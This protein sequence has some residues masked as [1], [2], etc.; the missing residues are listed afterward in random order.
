MVQDNTNLELSILNRNPSIIQGPD[1]LHE[2]VQTSSAQPAID[3]L[4]NGSKRQTYSYTTLHSLSDK[5]A[6]TILKISKEAKDS[7]T[8]IP[9]FL[10]QCPELYI[11]LLAILKAGKAFCPLNLDTPVERLKFIL[12]DLSANLLISTSTYAEQLQIATDTQCVLI[13]TLLSERNDQPTS[14]LPLINN[15]D[16]AYVLYTSGSTGLPKAVSVSHRAITQS[17]LAHDRHIPEFSRFL[18]FAAPTFDVSIFEIFF[19]W[20]RGRTLV[21]CTRTQMLDELPRI[22]NDLEVDAAEL[23]PTVVSNLLHGR[24]SVLGLKLLLTIGEMLTQYVIDEYGGDE[25]QESMLW[26][27]YGPTEAAVH[28]TLQPRLSKSS[29]IG[30]IGFP[31]DT[32]SSLIVT[33]A[34]EGNAPATIEILPKGEVGELVIAGPQVAKEYLNRPELTTA[35]FTNHPHYGYLYRTGDL[36]RVC[37]DKNLEFMGRVIAGQVKLR[38]Q[39]VE[40]GEIEKIVLKVDG[41]RAAIATIIED[42]L[43]VFCATG[44]RSISRADVLRTCRL[45]LPKSMVPSDVYFVSSMPQLPSGKVDKKALESKYLQKSHCERLV[46][47]DREDSVAQNVLRVLKE[48]TKH[49]LAMD[50]DLASVGLDSLKAIRVA[51]MLRQDGYHLGAVDILVAAT[52]E[53]LITICKDCPITDETREPSEDLENISI[54]TSISQL[55]SFRADVA[56][57]FRCT[58]L[59]EAMLAETM[60][61]PSAYCNW[62]EVDLSMSCTYEQIRDGLLSLT[63]A[64]E[65]L[66]TGFCSTSEHAATFVQIVWKGLLASQIREVSR[67]SKQYSLG[68][69]ESFLRPLTV[70]VK[71]GPGTSQVLFQIHHALYDGWSFDLILRDLGRL[72]HKEE[73]VQRPQYRDIVRWF[74]REQRCGEDEEHKKYWT[75][76]LHDHV[77]VTF[78]NYNGKLIDSPDVRSVSGRSAV[79]IDSLFGRAE[80]LRVNPQVFFQA[81]TA[82]VLSL[83]TGSTDIV[84]GNVTSGRTLPVTGIEDILGPCIA[85]VPFRLDFQHLS[86]VCDILHKTQALNRDSLQ[87]CS[88]PLRDIV[89]AVNVQ[90][91]AH[92]FEAL[93]VWQQPATSDSNASSVAKIIDSADDLEYKITLEFEPLSDCIKFRATFDPSTFPENQVKYLF[94]QIDEVVQLFLHDTD[95]KVIDISRCF[96]NHSRSIANPNPQRTHVQENPARSVEK[97]ASE[98]PDKEAIAF[99]HIVDGLIEVK[100][101]VTYEVLNTRANRLA[102]VLLKHGAGQ[103]QL[104]GVVMEKSIHLY[105]SILAILKV[106]S[107]YLP[108]VPDTP[109]DRIKTIFSDAQ[110]AICISESS[111][112]DRLG[113]GLSTK[114]LDFD[115]VDFSNYASQNLE[116]R[117]DGSHLAYAVFTSGSTGTPKGVLVTQDNLMSNLD[118]L[119]SIYPVSASSRMLQGSSQAF[120]VS[121]FEIFF[122][123]RVGICLCSAKK[124][125][126]FRDLDGTINRLNITHLSLTPT[127]AAMVEPKNVPGV[128]FLVTAGEALTE[129]VR[130]KWAGRNLYQ[131]N[132]GHRYFALELINGKATVHLKLPIFALS[133]HL[134]DLLI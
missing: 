3:F 16:L 70:Q 92:L 23:T 119:S 134:S 131:G 116:T 11:V 44:S 20:F 43:I 132:E 106:G 99:A 123:W 73:I 113:Q 101:T 129:R 104:I 50:S 56:C 68:S 118:Y 81:A 121:V 103:N 31:L 124:D 6:G 128:E 14:L 109:F 69:N 61:K 48:H 30:T 1:L 79:G 83:Y 32:V 18:Q 110:V 63:Q 130:R 94:Q 88:F 75:S 47:P 26:A 27:M 80:E 114:F 96:T 65:I 53:D 100:D 67:F 59:Q 91:G 95:C 57:I 77:S 42:T 15:D 93:F 117:Y 127:V 125:D 105:I 66:R 97:W 102:H 51:S 86:R 122:C 87:H 49:E 107:G 45:W 54:K 13:D 76:L 115:T 46:L 39:R 84:I 85:S 35:S 112:S 82:Y 126:V 5:L 25:C 74:A 108:L 17:L 58:P 72:L 41:C 22:I 111:V 28:C 4:E 29:P 133:M 120:D 60:A 55:E 64:N 38:G 19:P 8:I 21:G 89:K 40:L 37:G 78:P 10:P 33:P 9:V 52:L 98:S 7:S 71:P 62:I 2:L 12:Q 36:A 90:P 34:S 24:S